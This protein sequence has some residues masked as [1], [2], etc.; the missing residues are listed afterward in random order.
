[1]C[2]I[3]GIYT[4]TTLAAASRVEAMNKALKHRG[5]D[6]TGV[7]TSGSVALGHQRLSIIDLSS[8]GH[9]PMHSSDKRYT[10]V[11]NGEIY[12]YREIRNEIGAGSFHTNSDTEVLL[13]AWQRWGEDALQRLNG[14]FAFALYD[15]KSNDLYLVRD[16]L[17]IKPLYY[18][19]D[20]NNL[21]FASEIRSVMAS[22][23]VPRIV[24]KAGLGE[25]LRY[26][27]VHAPNTIVQDVKTLLPG[28]LM[29]VS[30]DGIKMKPWW[31][32]PG[33]FQQ[34]NAHISLSQA[35]STIHDLLQA[36]VERRLVAD[37]PFGAFLS[38]GID[39]SAVVGLM[40][41]VSSAPVKTFSVV[42]DESEFSEAR[43][44]QLVAKRFHTEHHEIQL[45]PSDFLH[46][47]PNALAAMDH[48]C[49]DGP[50]T[51]I[52]SKAT[53]NAGI[54]MALS[55]LGG[56]ELFAGYPI[57]NRAQQLEKWQWLSSIPLPLRRAMASILQS[58]KPGIASS[59]QADL[60]RLH[61]IDFAHGYPLARLLLSSEQLES[62][63]G[64]TVKVYQSVLE[65]TTHPPIELKGK[66]FL[67]SRVSVAEITTY[68]QNILLR[69][70]DQM[71]M[72]HALEVRVPFLDYTLVEYVL[73]LPDQLKKANFPK[74]LLVDSLGDL[75]PKEIVHRPKMGFTLPWSDWMK[76]ELNG[77]CSDRLT[78]L[79]KR[80]PFQA[81]GI[82]L[83]W[84]QFLQ[85]NPAVTWS[86]LW[87]LV[88]LEDWLVRNDM[89][90]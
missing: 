50:N 31:Q 32:L 41:G 45:K 11:F 14:M 34:E 16:R 46:D 72:A 59:K 43:Y 71:S 87:P 85:G 19:K 13:A 80:K 22:G 15:S 58:I 74:Q 44:A 51:Y 7:Y 55:G 35:H 70:T 48:P 49:G 38:G 82:Q 64:N 67:L 47:L 9:Q 60:L 69:D 78:N 90:L 56:D 65:L 21:V 73:S 40:S 33:N 81:E 18:W 66:N 24:D 53:R 57:F 5:P 52:V 89:E 17:G 77:F 83:L 63:G 68:M 23:M 42:F 29:K 86:R 28:H 8:A 54:T 61:E 39:S 20:A 1:M 3:T 12:N 36:S 88:V 84:Q 76:N 79:S 25:Y 75:L 26:Q 2:G 37:V 27:T 10:I 6:D 30:A 62:I 4:S